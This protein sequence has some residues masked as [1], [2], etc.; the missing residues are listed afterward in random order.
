M[1]TINWPAL[2]DAVSAGGSGLAERVEA[3]NPTY[4]HSIVI[5]VGA[6]IWSLL[7]AAVFYPAFQAMV[8]RWWSSG[9][10]FGEVTVTSRLRMGQV[11]RAYFRF[12]L[13]GMVFGIVLSIAGGLTLAVIEPLRGLLSPE[14]DELMLGGGFIVGYMILALGYSTVYQVTVK[15]SLW[16]LGMESAELSGFAALD[17]VKAGGR[18]TSALGEGLADAL[19]VG[20]F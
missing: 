15:L 9:L 13:Y 4:G 18:P 2:V 11:Y 5:T 10:R 6:A 20:G 19:N 1:Y 16:R 17:R 3:T 8:L 14:A 7:A 12:L